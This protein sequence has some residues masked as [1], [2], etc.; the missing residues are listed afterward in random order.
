[1][2]P[3][4]A[5]LAL[6][7]IGL[8]AALAH[9]PASGKPE[10]RLFASSDRCMAC[11]NRLSSPAGEDVSIGIAWRASMMANSARDPY[12]KASVRREIT[13][14]P[15]ARAAIEDE[16]SICHMPATTFAARARG[17]QGKLF[18]LLA[19]GSE[20][21]LDGVTCSLSPDPSASANPGASPATS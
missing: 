3:R 17:E 8:A 18:S 7:A 1:V 16:C 14:H 9:E 15:K 21:A 13:D 19:S 20:L 10:A 2:R 5:S 4:I 11:H 6:L 12:W